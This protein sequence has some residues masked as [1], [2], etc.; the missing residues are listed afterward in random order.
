MRTKMIVNRM[1]DWF[2]IEDIELNTSNLA[3]TILQKLYTRQI[4]GLE[5]DRVKLACEILHRKSAE[6]ISAIDDA[7]CILIS[8]N[9]VVLEQ[10]KY[11]KRKIMITDLGKRAF[12]E[13]RELI[14]DGT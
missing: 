5:Y 14:K 10:I 9:L 8:R 13:Y 12:E 7:L 6:T 11:G 1:N 3:M 4:Y 2:Q